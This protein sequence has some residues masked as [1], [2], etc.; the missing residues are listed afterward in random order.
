M[1]DA[2]PGWQGSAAETSV[3]DHFLDRLGNDV[4]STYGRL[5]NPQTLEQAYMNAVGVQQSGI[6]RCHRLNN[7]T[8]I[9]IS[10]TVRQTRVKNTNTN[11]Q[12]S[13]D[14]PSATQTYH[15][16]AIGSNQTALDSDFNANRQFNS[17]NNSTRLTRNDY[18]NNF[19]G[20]RRSNFYPRTNF[21][22][23][24]TINQS[25]QRQQY[26]NNYR[27]NPF[28]QQR[29]YQ[30]SQP[31]T[32]YSNNN[33]NRYFN[34]NSNLNAINNTQYQS[35]TRPWRRNFNYTRSRGSFSTR[36]PFRRNNRTYSTYYANEPQTQSTQQQYYQT[37][38]TQN[39]PD[40]TNDTTN[41]VDIKP[42]TYILHPQPPPARIH[43]QPS[44]NT[45]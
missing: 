20:R 19:R 41:N 2:E 12:L 21:G 23:Q 25:Q 36:F 42:P 6:I 43:Q 17:Q 8:A 5:G 30:S 27:N 1:N 38:H 13:T 9:Q 3:V 28:N 35:Q 32:N 26:L 31:N 14:N 40:S 22:T 34:N 18:Y 29:T 16:N 10:N 37:V 11:A 4:I 44:S 39:N 45:K 33:Q 15:T 24:N 7:T